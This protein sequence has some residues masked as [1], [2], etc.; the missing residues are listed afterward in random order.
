[1]AKPEMSA[2]R[3][4]AGWKKV[5]VRRDGKFIVG[6]VVQTSG[7]YLGL[8]LG[9]RVGRELRHVGTVEW[10]VGR[11]VVETLIP[12]ARARPDS[13][14]VDLRRQADVVWLEPGGVVEV[15][16]SE[17]VGGRLRDPVLRHLVSAKERA[18][19]A[20]VG[21]EAATNPPTTQRVNRFWCP[22]RK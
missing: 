15:S 21:R 11:G 22:K 2:Y 6:G 16:F 14:F 20:D 9:V 13:P 3:P 7:G 5:K 10:G 17:M 19:A 12:R 4:S 18:S 1:V 8:V